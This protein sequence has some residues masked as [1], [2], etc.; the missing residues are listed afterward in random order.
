[1]INKL[2]PTTRLAIQATVAVFLAALLAS[3]FHWQ[4]TY[5]AELTAMLMISQTLGDSIK[6]SVERVSMTIVG[7]IVG[8]LLFFLT[9]PFPDIQKTLLILS[10]FF[11]IFFLTSFYLWSVFFVSMLVVFLF[12]SIQ[13]WTV[14]LLGWRILETIFGA[15]MAVI[16]A[17]CVFPIRTSEKLHDELQSFIKHLS[18]LTLIGVDCLLLQHVDPNELVKQ[19][20]DLLN[21]LNTLQQRLITMRFELIFQ[22]LQRRRMRGQLRLLIHWYDLLSSWLE[23]LKHEPFTI[24]LYHRKQVLNQIKQ[25]LIHNANMIGQNMKIPANPIQTDD[26]TGDVKHRKIIPA[27]LTPM[28]RFIRRASS[29]ALKQQRV[30]FADAYRIYNHIHTLQEINQVIIQLNDLCPKTLTSTG[31]KK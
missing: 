10:L 21:E 16:A 2:E 14:S 26:M 23:T 29:L 13:N 9:A 27:D 24:N 7:G 8:T 17:A 5:W 18:Q 3:L 28:V 22:P 20:R 15:S 30:S 31:D 19:Q 11:C 12:A 6:K 25:L 1:M 4:R